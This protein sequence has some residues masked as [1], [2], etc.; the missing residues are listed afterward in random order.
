M[1]EKRREIVNDS[2]RALHALADLMPQ[3]HAHCSLGEMLE[4]INRAFGAS[5]AWISVYTDGLQR[6]VC[7]GEVTCH[8][9]EVAD[10]LCR[11][12]AGEASPCVAGRLLEREYRPRIILRSS[13]WLFAIAKRGVMQAFNP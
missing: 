13:S 9:F 12:P 3:L 5:L 7:A 10:F 8:S 2:L 1:K 4:T 6:V 11:Y